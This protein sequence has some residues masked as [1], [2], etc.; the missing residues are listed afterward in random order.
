MATVLLVLDEADATVAKD[1][2]VSLVAVD[3]GNER[4]TKPKVARVMA[5][6]VFSGH[7]RVN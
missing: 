4:G 1:E 3:D 6:L 5:I 7:L 2:D